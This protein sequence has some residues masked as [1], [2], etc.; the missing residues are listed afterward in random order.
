VQ[1]PASTQQGQGNGGVAQTIKSTDGAIGYVDYA[2][3][4]NSHMTMIA[5]KN[6]AGTVVKPGE[7]SFKAA[8]ASADFAKAAGM[9]P[10]L[11]DGADKGAWP[12]VTATY[13]LAYENGADPIHSKAVVD[14]FTWGLEKGP[15]LAQELGFVPLPE[16]VVKLVEAKMKQIK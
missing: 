13:I 2:D 9:A 11:I 7:E 14:F 12:I 10:D 6:K 16:T 8:A 1:W 15:K 3:A 5:L 4:K